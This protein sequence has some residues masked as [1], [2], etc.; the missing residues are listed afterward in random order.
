MVERSEREQAR[1][2]LFQ[3]PDGRQR[4]TEAGLVPNLQKLSAVRTGPLQNNVMRTP[5]Q[6]PFDDFE[7]LDRVERL[8]YTEAGVKVRR[9]MVVKL[10]PDYDPKKLT[11]R[12]HI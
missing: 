6:A 11:D 9:R 1:A 5:R 10:H 3:R 4:L 2:L 8:G 7:S 12:C